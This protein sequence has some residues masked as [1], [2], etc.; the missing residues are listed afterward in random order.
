MA[1]QEDAFGGDLFADWLDGLSPGAGRVSSLIGQL[2]YRAGG[3]ST[4]WSTPGSTKY[5][6]RDWHMQTGCFRDMFTARSSGGFEFDFPVSF[7]EPPLL[8]SSIAGT[9][10]SFEEA[11]MQTTVASASTVEVYWWST[12]NLTRIWVNWLALGPIGL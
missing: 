10:P 11:V 9:L 12:N 5:L 7:S 4:D 1:E 8:I 6:P 3:S 2:R